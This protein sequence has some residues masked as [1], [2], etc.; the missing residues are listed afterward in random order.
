MTFD[1]RIAVIVRDDL[2][3]WQKLNVAAFTISGIATLPAVTGAPY[4]D[5]AGRG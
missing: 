1:T 2:V 5:K 3:A 4:Q